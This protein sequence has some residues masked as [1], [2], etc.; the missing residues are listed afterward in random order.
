MK[1]FFLST[2]GIFLFT[3]TVFAVPKYWVGPTNGNW[4]NSSNW[5]LVAGGPGSAGMPDASDSVIILGNATINLDISPTIAALTIGDLS[6]ATNAKIYAGQSVVLTILRNFFIPQ[7][8]SLTD[9]TTTSVSFNVLFN[10]A[11]AARATIL[12]SWIFTGGSVLSDPATQG[13]YFTSQNNAAVTI[14]NNANINAQ[15]ILRENSGIVRSSAGTCQFTRFATCFFQ[16]KRDV[17]IPDA[18]WTPQSYDNGPSGGGGI[19]APAILRITGNVN[20][21]RH[22]STSIRYGSVIFDLPTITRE[23]SASFPNDSY[24]SGDLTVLNTNNQ[25]LVLMAN[26]T[27]ASTLNISYPFNTRDPGCDLIIGGATTRVALSKP[28]L[29]GPPIDFALNL[30]DSYRQSGGSFSLQDNNAPNGTVNMFLNGSIL[31]T[32]GVFFTNNTTAAPTD[33]FTVAFTGP[34]YVSRPS[35]WVSFPQRLTLASGAIESPQHAVTLVINQHR[36]L[37]QTFTRDQEVGVQMT[38]PVSVGKARFSQGILVSSLSNVLSITNPDSASVSVLSDSSYVQG[39]VRRVTNSTGAYLMPLGGNPNHTG[40]ALTVYN[41]IHYPAGI[42]MTPA[43]ADPSVYE[44]RYNNLPFPDFVN[45][46]LPLI[47]VANGRYWEIGRMTGA[48]ASVRMK[49]AGAIPG[50]TSDQALV[51]AHYKNGRWEAV[52]GSVLTPGNSASGTVTSR[53]MSEFG[54]FTFGVILPTEI[55]LAIHF[56]GFTARKMAQGATLDWSVESSP[57]RFEVMRSNNGTNYSGIGIVSA[58]VS[59]KTYQFTDNNLLPGTNYYRIKAIEADGNTSLSATNAVLNESNGITKTYLAPAFVQNITKL[60]ITSSKVGKLD[61]VVSDM[62][63]RT[64]KRMSVAVSIGNMEKQLDFSD[65]PAGIYQLT[66]TINQSKTIS[67]RFVK[68]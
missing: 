21:I 45:L 68:Q 30:N 8:S 52:N 60:F 42:E 5:S 44:A 15:I 11:T 56:T 28:D 59:K 4:N 66:G 2:F 29:T 26:T 17:V 67:L 33:R 47:Q 3:A 46:A 18:S 54:P 16:D 53:V 39:A 10:G 48:N 65:L 14:G 62:S 31:Q 58:E 40:S 37:N 20:S 12:G 49:L 13:A 23:L 36:R 50:A 19:L 6:V 57:A 9:S 43:S 35:G 27:P 61:L 64:R 24:I 34:L 22:L 25:T 51:V 7:F 1:R 55:P 32:G 63:G 41:I 38:T